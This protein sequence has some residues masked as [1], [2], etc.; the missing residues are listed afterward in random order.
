MTDN[1]ENAPTTPQRTPAGGVAVSNSPASMKKALKPVS[2]NKSSNTYVGKLNFLQSDNFDE[3]FHHIHSVNEQIQQQLSGVEVQTRQMS[4]DV[5]QLVD[6]L[7]NNNSSLTKVLNQIASYSDDVITEGYE[8]KNQISEII[9]RLEKFNGIVTDLNTKF[10]HFE[11]SIEDVVVKTIMNNTKSGSHDLTA[12]DIAE[13]VKAEVSKFQ[14]DTKSAV[15]EAIASSTS[16]TNDEQLINTFSE[17]KELINRN[18]KNID[19]LMGSETEAVKF[20]TRIEELLSKDAHMSETQVRLIFNETVNQQHQLSQ[21]ILQNQKD[22]ITLTDIKLAVYE[23][24]DEYKKLLVSLNESKSQNIDEETIRRIVSQNNEKQTTLVDRILENQKGAL[25][26]STARKL[27]IDNFSEHKSQMQ[28]FW[29]SKISEQ[30]ISNVSSLSKS[31]I[32]SQNHLAKESSVQELLSRSSSVHELT[33]TL[34]DKNNTMHCEILEKLAAIQK[35][36]PEQTLV[37]Q[38]VEPIVQEL[39]ALSL[40]AKSQKLLEDI[41]QMLEKYQGNNLQSHEQQMEKNMHIESIGVDVRNF[42][43]NL[44]NVSDNLLELK[45]K[46]IVEL[47]TKLEQQNTIVRDALRCKDLQHKQTELEMKIERLQEKYNQMSK[48]YVNQYEELVSLKQEYDDFIQSSRNVNEIEQDYNRTQKV[49]Q[50]HMN[51]MRDLQ[52]PKHGQNNSKR[53][54]SSPLLIKK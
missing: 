14:S 29:E 45:D 10:P 2:P 30:L 19:K 8:T 37:K 36:L 34:V 27:I 18:S 43:E 31:V 42:S 4:V 5:G 13:A 28:T 40:D 9:E 33:G 21:E 22:S 49:R 6:R 26:E 24:L 54:V 25:N 7:K 48:E 38:I 47:Q 41:F 11:K 46:Q 51:K 20:Y 50:L 3:H 1:K 39:S 35:A 15:L 23:S 52:V 32:G 17:L 53:I 12:T 16:S 44:K